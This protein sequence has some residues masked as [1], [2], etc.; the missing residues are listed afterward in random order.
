ML[1]YAFRLCFVP[2]TYI[3]VWKVNVRLLLNKRV[4][5]TIDNA[6]GVQVKE[7]SVFVGNRAIGNPLVLLLEKPHEPWAV[8]AAVTFCPDADAFVAGLVVRELGKPGLRKVPQGV[9]GLSSAVGRVG[10]LL[11]AECANHGRQVQIW[12]TLREICRFDAEAI[13]REVGRAVGGDVIGEAN[14]G[15]LVDV[16]HVDLIIPA[17]GIEH[18]RL[19]I[20]IYKAGAIFH[21]EAVHGRGAGSSIEPNGQRSRR[22]VLASFKEPEESKALCQITQ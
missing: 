13:S 19:G 4:Q 8:V 11:A 6:K 9:G 7:M 15:G 1:C 12:Y 10:L 22:R 3:V 16:Q 14:L 18:S 17:P 21:E 2:N 20:V 5:P